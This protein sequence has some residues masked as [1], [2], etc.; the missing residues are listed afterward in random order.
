[1]RRELVCTEAAT[2]PRLAVRSIE[3]PYPAKGN[4]LVRVQATSAN[5]IDAKRAAGYGR[6]LLGL[7]GAARFPLVLGNDVAG[8]V[9]AIG[10]GVTRFALGQR[11]FGLLGT[12]R[13]RRG[14]QCP[15]TRAADRHRP[16]LRQRYRRVR[17]RVGRPTRPSGSPAV[18]STSTW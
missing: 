5:P 8:V 13:A 12:G 6:R 1:M 17:P 11:V 18:T 10:A 2:P 4:V 15:K 9:E 14:R 3:L 7:K 16:A